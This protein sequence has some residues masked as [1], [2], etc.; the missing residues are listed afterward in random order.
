MLAVAVIS[1]LEVTE[2]LENTRPGSSGVSCVFESKDVNEP[3][4]ASKSETPCSAEDGETVRACA[5]GVTSKG[6]EPAA[7]IPFTVAVMLAGAERLA[8]EVAGMR[9]GGTGTVRVAVLLPV[10]AEAAVAGA[11]NVC[12]DCVKAS[13]LLPG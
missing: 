3:T 12:P 10:A 13:T 4:N 1:V 9:P 11:R 5:G 7:R 8:A 6:T 2:T